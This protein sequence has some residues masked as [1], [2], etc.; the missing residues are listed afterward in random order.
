[1]I[2]TFVRKLISFKWGAQGHPASR[3]RWA[4]SMF[5]LDLPT[6]LLY[7]VLEHLEADDLFRTG[8]TCRQFSLL[9]IPQ[10]YQYCGFGFVRDTADAREWAGRLPG[11]PDRRQFV[12]YGRA[13]RHVDIWNM[14]Q[15]ENNPM[16]IRGRPS[17]LTLLL[18]RFT[19]LR[20]VTIQQVDGP[21]APFK[22]YV[23]ALRQVLTTCMSL[24]DLYID[25]RYNAWEVSKL[26]ELED[27]LTREPPT[28]QPRLAGLNIRL[29]H[30]DY[31]NDLTPTY[32]ALRLICN[33]IGNSSRTVQDFKFGVGIYDF[34]SNFDTSIYDRGEWPLTPQNPDRPKLDLQ[35][36]QKIELDLTETA[37]CEHMF[38]EYCN[39][40]TD[41]IRELEL[42]NMTSQEPYT[43]EQALQ[44]FSRF[45]YLRL[46]QPINI[47]RLEWIDMVFE[48]KAM[49]ELKW[50]RELRLSMNTDPPSDKE[51]Y[52]ML[53]KY[54]PKCKWMEIIKHIN[55]SEDDDHA[56]AWTAEF[57]F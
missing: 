47:E 39:V 22:S 1:M 43:L 3:W 18:P 56:A 5:L 12:K 35:R 42:W 19:S 33:L 38:F 29:A 21:S 53:D 9:A 16:S 54:A 36:L 31:N 46:I 13:V 17:H 34:S 40:D 26:R 51:L 4:Q 55:R 14:Y 27:R 32:R 50:L 2:T 28:A 10:L 7:M 48:V 45:P 11:I 25:L 30:T 57:K 24:E 52:R 20:S 49:R 8:L 41:I 6:E 23:S 37:L 15:I 44:L